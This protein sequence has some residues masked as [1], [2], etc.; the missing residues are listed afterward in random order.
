MK[1]VRSCR[2]VSE[3][4]SQAQ[5]RP[6]KPGEKFALYVHLPLCEGCR[7]FRRQLAFMRRALREYLRR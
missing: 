7:N 3:L 1:I 5:D 2:E 4:L 6:L